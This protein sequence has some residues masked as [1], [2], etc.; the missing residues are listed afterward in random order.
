MGLRPDTAFGCA[1]HFLFGGLAPEARAL[2]ELQPR[3]HEA[4]VDERAIKIGI[5][6]RLGD[7][8]ILEQIAS[9]GEVRKLIHRCGCEQG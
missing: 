6:I 8:H 2:A 1:L 3:L 9:N 5:Q 4:M 7:E